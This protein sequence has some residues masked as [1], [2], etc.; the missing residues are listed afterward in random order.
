MRLQSRTGQVVGS[1]LAGL[2]GGLVVVVVVGG[3]LALLIPAGLGVGLVSLVT[4]IGD[5]G[6]PNA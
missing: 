6:E 1:V 2:A 3:S 4:V 5:D